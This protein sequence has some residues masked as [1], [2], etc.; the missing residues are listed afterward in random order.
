MKGDVEVTPAVGYDRCESGARR[1]MEVGDGDETLGG[2][3]AGVDGVSGDELGC[4]D[5]TRWNAG[6]VAGVGI[7][8][9]QAGWGKDGGGGGGVG[10]GIE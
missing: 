10:V 4:G 8:L 2:E 9:G 7:T 1:L 5:R 3:E 6:H